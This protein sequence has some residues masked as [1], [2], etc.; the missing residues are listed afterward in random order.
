MP[1]KVKTS[2]LDLE[3]IIVSSHLKSVKLPCHNNL[4]GHGMFTGYIVQPVL[5]DQPVCQETTLAGAC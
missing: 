1:W 3:E 5:L 4:Y 2:D